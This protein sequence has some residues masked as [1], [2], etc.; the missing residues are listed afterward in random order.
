MIP[1]E[2]RPHPDPE[3]QRASRA[4][5]GEIRQAIAAANG[6]LSFADYMQR[7]LYAPQL[8]YY[9]RGS[10]PLGRTGD[11]V[12]APEL[13]PLFGQALARQ[14]APIL[15]HS[16]PYLLEAG[17]GSGAL[18][19][20]L[21][22]ALDEL[23]CPP[24][25]YDII[26]LSGT[27]AV[28]QRQTIAARAPRLY[29]RVRWLGT[30]PERFSGCLIANE[31]LDA[32]PV[33]RLHWRDD[34]LYERGIT[35][36]EA[37]ALCW[38]ERPASATLAAAA[39][40]L[41][42]EPPYVGEI[43]LIARAWVGELGRRLECGALLFIDYG[44]PRAELYHPQRAGGTLRC[45]YRQRVHDDPLWW[46]GLSD[47][48]AHVD[49]TA[50]AEAGHAAGLDLLGYAPQAGFL[51]GCGLLDLLAAR[52]QAGGA[53]AA[54]AMGAA[55]LLLSPN[56]MGEIFKVIALGRGLPVPLQAFARCDR[57]HTL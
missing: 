1:P 2:P 53:N 35:L 48:T 24:I 49:F 21:L 8:G 50:I 7:A 47:I 17:A 45:H 54:R 55:Q 30:L 3:D 28:R 51:L 44:L 57:R 46:P 41:P 12:T 39:A 10:D 56:E 22:L 36:D 19:A 25:R 33:H 40:M 34:G 18:A 11:F 29:E 32:L 15:A 5:L 16:A 20:D 6:W 26:E 52:Q 4:L 43:G 14:I 38:Q 27:L 13:T 42:V 37:G 31:V 9:D 23:G